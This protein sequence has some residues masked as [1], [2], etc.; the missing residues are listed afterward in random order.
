[1]PREEIDLIVFWSSDRPGF[2][3]H[4]VNRFLPNPSGLCNDCSM[5]LQGTWLL[6]AK[7]KMLVLYTFLATRHVSTAVE[8]SFSPSASGCRACGALSLSKGLGVALPADLRRNRLSKGTGQALFNS[9]SLM[10][11]STLSTSPPTRSRFENLIR[12]NQPTNQLTKRSFKN[13]VTLSK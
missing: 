5:V 8:R 11:L 7:R 12:T 9:D 1:M 2:C 10:T 3:F 13:K 4:R 6:G